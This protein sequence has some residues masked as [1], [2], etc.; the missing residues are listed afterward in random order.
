[1]DGLYYTRRHEWVRFFGD[2]AFVGTTGEDLKGDVV[3]VELP[4][5]GARVGEGKPGAKVESVKADVDVRSPIEG[6]V[7]AVNDSV[8]DDPDA[9]AAHP[10]SVWLFKVECDEAQDTAGLLTETEYQMI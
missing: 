1:M 4:E 6:V 9:I 8:Y 10:M 5:I 2:I 3:Y 7:T